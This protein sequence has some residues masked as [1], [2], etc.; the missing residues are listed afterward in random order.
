MKKLIALI[1]IVFLVFVFGCLQT[2]PVKETV[3]APNEGVGL[4][5]PGFSLLDKVIRPNSITFLSISIRNNAEGQIAKNVI[6]SIDNIEP[7][8]LVSCN[9]SVTEPT[10]LYSEIPECGIYYDLDMRGKD[11][12][13]PLHLNQH[14]TSELLQGQELELMW[15]LKSP[16]QELL[17]GICMCETNNNPHL[18]YYTM[19]YDYK[20]IAQENIVYMS[21]DEY[22][23]I[24]Q[25]NGTVN[26]P[27]TFEQTAGEFQISHLT[28]IP[29]LYFATTE[30][31]QG[32]DL[33]Y[34]I[35]NRGR[36]FS[37]SG[38]TIVIEYPAQME[39]SSAYK[40]FGWKTSDELNE[41]EKTAVRRN[42]PEMNM[43]N[44]LVR[45]ISEDRIR[46]GI[47]FPVTAPL[48]LKKEELGSLIAFSIPQKTYNVGVYLYYTYRVENVGKISVSP[49]II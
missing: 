47:K 4:A 42:F 7:F 16:P 23:K 26:I 21:N 2:G 28:Q 24:K 12:A 10:T 45:Q 49:A 36:G 5:L 48:E 25:E 20:M 22:R 3:L 34:E 8:K 31:A 1:S 38:I 19:D 46:P 30:L 41:E 29:K 27:S 39:P 37:P 17:G 40:D 15:T 9:G 33:S 6:V 14:G 13:S 18:L 44:I 32:T 43:E 35:Y 11:G